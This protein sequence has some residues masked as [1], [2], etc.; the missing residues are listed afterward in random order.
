MNSLSNAWFANIFFHCI[1]GLFTLLLFPLLWRS[2]IVWCNHI[3]VLLLFHKFCISI[4]L[5]PKKKR[6]VLGYCLSIF[7]CLK[8]LFDFRLYFISGKLIVQENFHITV[9]FPIFLLLLIYSFISL[10]SKKMPDMTSVFFNLLVLTLWPNIWSMFENVSCALEQ[11]VFFCYGMECFVYVL[12]P[13]G[14]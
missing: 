12:G 7:T 3:R 8:R 11:N 13:F 2:L 1:G 6:Q 4:I 9:D 10:W 14:L 5:H